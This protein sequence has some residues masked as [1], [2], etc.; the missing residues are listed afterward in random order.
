MV[1]QVKVSQLKK[2]KK[3]V[4]R[5]CK[6]LSISSKFIKALNSL[7]VPW[8]YRTPPTPPLVNVCLEMFILA[9]RVGKAEAMI[10]AFPNT[11]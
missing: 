5:S 11:L 7:Q 3:L 4:T 2:K 6:S 9:K 1:K 10:I 8:I